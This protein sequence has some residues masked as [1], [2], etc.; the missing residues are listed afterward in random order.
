[1]ARELPVEERGA[2]KLAEDT[3]VWM[4]EAVSYNQ[5]DPRID[6]ALEA[7][8]HALVRDTE[9]EHE[10]ADRTVWTCMSCGHITDG[11]CCDSCGREAMPGRWVRAETS[12]FLRAFDA[13]QLAVA[14]QRESDENF[15]YAEVLAKAL[16]Q[17][18]RD[19]LIVGC[20]SESAEAL[21]CRTWQAAVAE[22]DATVEPTLRAL[23]YPVEPVEAS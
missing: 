14:L 8:A 23:G 9:R 18:L 19:D 20:L 15:G 6:T 13:E 10:P 7:I 1:M 5:E 21:L 17:F 22:L 16:D 3:I 12:G 2:L 11:Q 4:R